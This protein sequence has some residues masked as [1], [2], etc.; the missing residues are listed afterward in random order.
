VQSFS[1]ARFV[2]MFVRS[3]S[4]SSRRTLHGVPEQPLV[5]IRQSATRPGRER[6]DEGITLTKEIGCGSSW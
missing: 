4:S 3:D 2:E 5:M 6:K 1:S